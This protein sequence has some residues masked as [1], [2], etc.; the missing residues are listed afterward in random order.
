MIE[1]FV[2]LFHQLYDVKSLIQWGGLAL[3]CL[4]LFD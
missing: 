4:I 3:I 2:D 1:T